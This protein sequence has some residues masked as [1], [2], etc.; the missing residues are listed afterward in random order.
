MAPVSVYVYTVK[1]P[2]MSYEYVE[3]VVRDEPRVSAS[4]SRR[5]DPN[6]DARPL[7]VDSWNRAHPEDPRSYDD[8]TWEAP[9][10]GWVNPNTE[11]I[12]PKEI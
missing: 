2:G 3:A 12:K 4:A 8:F 11:P 5:L 9:P 7:L 1:H 10:A 6:A